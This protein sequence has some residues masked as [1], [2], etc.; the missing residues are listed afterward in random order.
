[1]YQN[2][3]VV[4]LTHDENVSLNVNDIEALSSTKD[5]WRS[6]GLDRAIMAE[7]E[8]IETIEA[9]LWIERALFNFAKSNDMKLS[10]QA[11]THRKGI[12]VEIAIM[13]TIDTLSYSDVLE[14]EF[15]AAEVMGQLL[16]R[17]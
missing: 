1:M 14:V 2:R 17:T 9:R 4:F 6:S 11:R 15:Q 10:Q 12:D 7:H 8:D 3:G 13:E 5:E 16:G